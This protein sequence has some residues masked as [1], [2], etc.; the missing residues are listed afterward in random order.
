MKPA[1]LKRHFAA[2]ANRIGL[3]LD[4]LQGATLYR[5]SQF[6][7]ERRNMGLDAAQAKVARAAFNQAFDER[8]VRQFPTR[9]AATISRKRL[10]DAKA[11]A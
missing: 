5:D 3:R 4:G 6:E 8:I 9:P 2:H 7:F 1:D 11:A 10:S